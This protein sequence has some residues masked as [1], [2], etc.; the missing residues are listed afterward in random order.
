MSEFAVAKQ[1]LNVIFVSCE[2]FGNARRK[3]NAEKIACSAQRG[4]N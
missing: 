2:Y 3:G 1:I 4:N